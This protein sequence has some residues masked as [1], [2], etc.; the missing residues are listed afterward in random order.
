[1]L[2]EQSNKSLASPKLFDMLQIDSPD[3]EYT[4]NSCAGTHVAHGRRASG[5]SVSSVESS[6]SYSLPTLI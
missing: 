3:F 4:I 2:D 1:M 6:V 5:C